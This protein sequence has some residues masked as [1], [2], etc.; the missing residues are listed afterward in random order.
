V[1]IRKKEPKQ[2]GLLFVLSGPSGAGKDAV[3]HRMKELSFPFYRV[4]TVTTRT[5]RPGENNGVDYYF[6]SE[7][8]FQEMVRRGELLERAEVYGRWYGTPKQQVKE[9]LDGGKDVI[10]R[11]DVQGAATIRSIM[12]EAVLIFLTSLLLE[13]EE[14][15]RQR[16][17]ESDG[18]RRLRMGRIDGE[19][20]SLPLFDYMVV[21][22]Q[23]E[24]D[25]A[26][27]QIMSIVT[28][29]KCRVNRRL[30]KLE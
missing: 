2:A 6:T 7:A 9:A 17:T 25:S 26:V 18:E 4:V 16:Q 11:V 24:L 3:L 15:L 19:M 22:H 23:G 14:R 29:E 12:P 8:E 30:V 27:S 20:K 28:A 13:Y 5:Q 1:E 21:N 10:L